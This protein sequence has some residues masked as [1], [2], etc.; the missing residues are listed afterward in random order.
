MRGQIK[1]G[2][3]LHADT[4]G[5]VILKVH[6]ASNFQWPVYSVFANSAIVVCP[7][8]LAICDLL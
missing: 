1:E 3:T 7:T 2:S 6:N 4:N 8:N 5:E